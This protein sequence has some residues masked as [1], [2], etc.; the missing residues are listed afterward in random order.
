MSNP[1]EQGRTAQQELDDLDLK[2]S[3]RQIDHWCRRKYIKAET[4]G[5][6]DFRRFSE[7][8]KRILKLMDRLVEAGFKPEAAARIA[9]AGVDALGGRDKCKIRVKPELWVE[10]HGI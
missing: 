6:G 10:V 7:V 3:F 4:A 8:E 2:A 9:R 5:S 1:G